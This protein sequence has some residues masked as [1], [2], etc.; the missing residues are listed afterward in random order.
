MN[1]IELIRAQLAVERQH[2]GAV[3][4]ACAETLGRAGP[5]VPGADGGLGEFRGACVE[6]LVYVLA[7][8]EERDQRLAELW[9]ARRAASETERSALDALLNGHGRSREALAQLEVALSASAAHARDAA[10]RWREFAA[11]FNGIWSARR[12]S[13]DGLL[14]GYTRTRDWR[15]FGVDADS[16]LEERRR[17]ARVGATLPAGVS[18]SAP[19]TGGG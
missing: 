6:Y 8:F 3:A 10:D 1:E 18:L 15:L 17:Y 19:A 7:R 11:F 13:I 16:L 5:G 2:A 4:N 12:D 9:R 14:A